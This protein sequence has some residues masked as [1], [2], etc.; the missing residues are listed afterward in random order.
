MD[1]LSFKRLDD[2]HFDIDVIFSVDDAQGN[3]G[4]NVV[5]NGNVPVT[6]G[7]DGLTRFR[8]SNNSSYP[9]R[10]TLME[11]IQIGTVTL[12]GGVLTRVFRG[13]QAVMGGYYKYQQLMRGLGTFVYAQEGNV[14]TGKP[15]TLQITSSGG[16]SQSLFGA[17]GTDIRWTDAVSASPFDPYPLLAL[18]SPRTGA[19]AFVVPG[20]VDPNTYENRNSVLSIAD[21]GGG[22]VRVASALERP[23][24]GDNV[25]LSDMSVSSYNGSYLVVNQ[26]GS[27]R[28]DISVPFAGTATGIWTALTAVTA[29][30]FT[31][32]RWYDF[33][34][35]A[36]IY[37][38]LAQYTSLNDA[39]VGALTENFVEPLITAASA[40]QWLV[41]IEQGTIDI[42]VS[43]TTQVSYSKL[44][45]LR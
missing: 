1:H 28:F 15:G 25:T 32:Q 20:E 19:F 27:D 43:N 21:V 34:A 3:W 7:E 45:R 12:A 37:Y 11:E 9:A 13:Y 35:F 23:N 14:I 8:F 22:L 39:I 2:D 24:A 30:N 26:V 6:I 33:G 31:N 42:G 18:A 16:F 44:S 41:S 38:G 29:S 17:G 4:A 40:Q 10:E 36:A 5:L